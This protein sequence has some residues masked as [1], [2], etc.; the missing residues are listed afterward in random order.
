MPSFGNKKPRRPPGYGA[1]RRLSGFLY[2]LSRFR[3][4][5]LVVMQQ[6][7]DAIMH[8]MMQSNSIF[9]ELTSLVSRIVR[10]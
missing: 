1:A 9:Q 8:H 4:N 6:R 7:Y 5:P 3:T 10:L 2:S